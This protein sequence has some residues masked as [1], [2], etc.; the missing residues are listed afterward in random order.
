MPRCNRGIHQL[1]FA[2]TV[3]W[4]FGTVST[5]TTGIS[6][7]RSSRNSFELAVTCPAESTN[8]ITQNSIQQCFVSHVPTSASCASPSTPHTVIASVSALTIVEVPETATPVLLASTPQLSKIIQTDNP[9]GAELDTAPVHATL[10][11][12][13][14]LPGEDGQA[15]DAP[16]LLESDTDAFLDDVNFLSF[17][18]WR[19]QNL[20]KI[21]QSAEDVGQG[22]NSIGSSQDRSRATHLEGTLDSIGDD[23]EIEL[24][25]GGFGGDA[26]TSG[27][28]QSADSTV[29]QSGQAATPAAQHTRNKD[30]G[31]T[32]K[33][34]F[35]Y[36]SFDCAANVLK[37]NPRCKSSSS[38][39]MENKD[40]YMLNECG[41]DNK[42][43]IVEL[44]DDILV[45]TVV[46][47]NFEFFS[48]MFRT[49]KISVSDRYPVKADRWKELGTYEARNSRDIQAFLVETPL[50]WARYLR[51]EFLTH[52]GSEFYCPLS[53][54]RVHGTTMM[55][56]F[57]HQEELARGE[58]D[59]EEDEEAEEEAISTSSVQENAASYPSPS[60]SSA[61]SAV[62]S[63]V[64]DFREATPGAEQTMPNISERAPSA[65]C[66][67]STPKIAQMSGHASGANDQPTSVP[68]QN[69]PTQGNGSN[70]SIIVESS[71]SLPNVAVCPSA[72]QVLNKSYNT[73]AFSTSQT[74]AVESFTPPYT[75]SPSD[76]AASARRTLVCQ[77]AASLTL[78]SKAEV[79]YAN[80]AS[81]EKATSA[82]LP[83][84]TTTTSTSVSSLTEP[85]SSQAVPSVNTT[86][87]LTSST[88]F[89]T[90]VYPADRSPQGVSR[91]TSA[92]S[93]PSSASQAPSPPATQESFFKS[94]HKRLQYLESNTSLS[95]QYIEL[96]SQLLRDALRKVERRNL[97]K[98][99]TFLE[100]LNASVVA[101]LVR[102]KT[103]YDSLWQTTVLD[104]AAQREDARKEAAASAINVRLLADEI[105]SQKR[106]MAVQAILLLFCL[107]LVIF[108]RTGA[109][110]GTDVGLV[111]SLTP[112]S[113]KD[114]R[115]RRF[116]WDSPWSPGRKALSPRSG[117]SSEEER[118]R[119]FADDQRNNGT[120]S[121]V[122]AR[123]FA[124]STPLSDRSTTHDE[125]QKP[126]LSIKEA[127]NQAIA[128]APIGSHS[129]PA[130]PAPSTLAALLGVEPDIAGV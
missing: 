60:N 95:L 18:E 25:F 108:A 129:A 101:E 124:P 90:S 128:G 126:E 46:L 78:P 71:N 45:D 26:R 33:G 5:T 62:K 72:N 52:Y 30:A 80:D 68:L 51:V 8:H 56:E 79:S 122:H 77:S 87:L 49:F 42:F 9:S 61:S 85:M 53:L 24:P 117:L 36:A 32:S 120:M 76:S 10:V 35:N 84:I 89:Q 106:L 119:G 48:S 73:S 44:C 118:E 75:S 31:K 41:A 16:L 4:H 109:I 19:S 65:D 107:G 15:L 2:V 92:V 57:R 112:R 29:S 34:R 93:A 96:Q 54:L 74:S 28:A 125:R 121:M 81:S 110:A 43:I 3:S 27:Q 98:T 102:F 67:S 47:A 40:R 91:A 97:V 70:T 105:V 83:I 7:N 113:G 55:A 38:I 100:A 39:L 11:V 123:D 127:I 99:T 66:I 1:L 37:T 64:S 50:I 114:G 130:T 17:D 21:G 86:S 82:S 69:P 20:A 14:P 22:R 94:I 6:S 103:D 13:S 23:G 58:V 111:P 88:P 104:L 12:S 116:N 63:P 115:R 59:D